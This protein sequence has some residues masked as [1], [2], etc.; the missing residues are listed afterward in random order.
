MPVRPKPVWISSAMNNIPCC[1]ANAASTWTYSTGA[2]TKPP[3]PSS[4]SMMTAATDAGSTVEA[5]ICSRRVASAM[6]Q[7]PPDG[8]SAQR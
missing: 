8:P 7:R 1:L 2:G 4:S 6:Q 3:S 5:R